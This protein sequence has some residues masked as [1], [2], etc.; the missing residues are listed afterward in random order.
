MAYH[1]VAAADENPA[2]PKVRKIATSDLID[3]LA[4]GFDDFRAMPTTNVIFL[5]LIYPVVGLILARMTF[6]YDVV[7]L[8]FP[9]AAGFALLGPLAAIW[10]YEL[11][12]RREQGLDISWRHAFDVFRARS[13]GAI[14]ALGCLLMVTFLVWVAIAHAI[15]VANFGYAAPTSLTQFLRD[16]FTTRAGWTL[17]I[18][19]NGV[20]FLFAVAVLAISV[21]S[22]PLLL[23]R[24]V[25][26]VAAATTSVSAV[27][28]NPVPMALWGL[29]VAVALVVGSIPFLLGLA[30]VMPVL[31]HATW[32][33]YRKVVEADHS[34]PQEY[35]PPGTQHRYAAEFPASL[36]PSSR[37]ERR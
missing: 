8:L 6:G 23:D 20:G 13:F 34:P 30:V 10:M 29:I 3:A 32:H 24:N 18:V 26:P 19:G 28:T 4:R 7:P 11:S 1:N 14:A 15:Y 31:G 5:S 9:L 37:E 22:F 25:G 17:I 36:F 16:V 35:R 27:V 2:L 12:R 21:V 33:L